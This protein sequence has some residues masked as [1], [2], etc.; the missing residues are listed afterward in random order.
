V[1]RSIVVFATGSSGGWPNGWCGPAGGRSGPARARG[2]HQAP[3][4]LPSRATTPVSHYGRALLVVAT[5]SVVCWFTRSF[6]SLADQ[7]MIYLLGVLLV[8]STLERGPSLVA[9]VVSVAALDLF[10][11]PPYFTFAVGDARHIL[12]F[13]VLL[14]TAVLVSRQTL[15]IR[16]QA[17]SAREREHRTVT[18]TS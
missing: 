13:A 9:A 15:L 1:L 5:A 17:D 4:P 3:P 10:F 16:E 18:S 14:V 11:V 2:G 6:F 7:A 12:T 8:S